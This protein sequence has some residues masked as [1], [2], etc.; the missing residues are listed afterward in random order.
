MHVIAVNRLEPSRRIVGGQRRLVFAGFGLQGWR[1]H[2]EKMR[3][4][5]RVEFSETLRRRRERRTRGTAD[6]ADPLGPQKL[7]GGEP[8]HCLLGRDGETRVA[9]Q[10]SKT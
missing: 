4:E 6:V 2:T 1:H 5:Q 7:D 10:R 3:I 8:S 9:Q